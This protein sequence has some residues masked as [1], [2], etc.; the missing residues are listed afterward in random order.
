MRHIYFLAFVL[1]AISIGYAE[2]GGKQQPTLAGD[3]YLTEIKTPSRTIHIDRAAL[4][5]DGMGDVFS[6]RFEGEERV[7]GKGAPN[8]YTAPVEWGDDFTLSIGTAA[9]TLM[10]AFK[11]PE[12]LKEREFFDYLSQVVRYSFGPGGRLE[13][14]TAE[15]K[16]GRSYL[17]FEKSRN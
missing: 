17:I 6:L 2:A 3:W 16:E 14:L 5:A 15:K 1:F 10:M 13:L 11:E 12:A 8:R 4:E 9:A 7:S